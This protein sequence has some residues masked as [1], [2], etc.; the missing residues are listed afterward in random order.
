MITE[1]CSLRCRD[2]SNLMQ[3]FKHPQDIDSKQLLADINKL[4]LQYKV[5]EFRVLGGEPFLNKDWEIV[6]KGLLENP[7]A[8]RIVILTNGTII[9]K[10]KYLSSPKILIIITDYGNLSS[11]LNI[12]TN[13]FSRNNITYEILLPRWTDCGKIQ[14]HNYTQRQLKEIYRKCCARNPTLS[15]HKLYDCAFSANLARLGIYDSE[16]SCDYCN[17]RPLGAKTI[18]PAVQKKC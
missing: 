11:K 13:L 4:L 10:I 6:I 8:R 2:C 12:L 15:N 16:A 1:R 14:K 3:Y 18:K 7:K 9:P 17:G 5:G